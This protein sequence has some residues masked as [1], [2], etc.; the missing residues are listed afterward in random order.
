MVDKTQTHRLRFRPHFKTHQSHAI[1]QWFR[2]EGVTAIT[3]S[4]ASMG[5]YFAQDGWE[6]ITLAF[7]VN[8]AE[9]DRINR[10]AKRV[11]LNLVVE[12]ATAI[13]YLQQHLQYPVGIYV[14]IDVGAGRTGLSPTDLPQLEQ[15]AQMLQGANRMHWKGWLAHAG[16]TYSCRSQQDII[17]MHEHALLQLTTLKA[18]FSP[19]FP[20]LEISLGDTPSA[21]VAP[22][23]EGIDEL[24][25]G[26][27]VFY[28]LMQYGIG[29][30]NWEDQALCLACPIVALHPE[31][32]EVVVYGGAVHLSKEAWTT[33]TGQQHFGQIVELTGTGWSAS[34]I[35]DTRLSRLSQEHGIIQTSK[36]HFSRFKLGQWL[37]VL[38]VHA[39]LTANAMGGYYHL[40]GQPIDH[41]N[42]RRFNPDQ[43]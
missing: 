23:F 15:L 32:L 28:D 14:K 2:D 19:T 25:P 38:P 24:R 3:V 31:R 30:C 11:H 20:Q 27:F 43:E 16:N 10:L 37:G 29:S 39:C 21:S 4:S 36:E 13:Q 35:P 22:H 17:R 1:G 41:L 34:A 33:D 26:V 18:H 8:L 5:L 9:M 42:G 40:S 12:S 7:P 6:D